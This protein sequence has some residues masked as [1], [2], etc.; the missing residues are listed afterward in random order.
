MTDISLHVVQVEAWQ[1]A[2]KGVGIINGSCWLP[3]QVCI[4]HDTKGKECDVSL[5]GMR[6]IWLLT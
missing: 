3:Y 4:E 6:S 1:G 2:Y 5:P